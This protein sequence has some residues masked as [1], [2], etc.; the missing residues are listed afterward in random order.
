MSG[1]AGLGY[2]SQYDRRNSRN[3]A[4]ALEAVIEGY[5]ELNQPRPKAIPPIATGSFERFI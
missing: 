4:D 2:G 1:F 5:E 3:V